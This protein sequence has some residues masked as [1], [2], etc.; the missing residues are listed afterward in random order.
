LL[1]VEAAMLARLP[2]PTFAAVLWRGTFI[3]TGLILVVLAALEELHWSLGVLGVALAI[4][5]RVPSW[6]KRQPSK[7]NRSSYTTS[8]LHARSRA[9]AREAMRHRTQQQARQT[10]S[11]PPV[12]TDMT[13]EQA[14]KILGLRTNATPREIKDAHRRLMRKAHPDRGGSSQMAA[15]INRAKDLLMEG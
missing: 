8:Q 15:Q 1:V 4:M 14:F 9:A 12:R 10:K 7:A 13:R 11:T 2:R 6:F 5:E 3:V